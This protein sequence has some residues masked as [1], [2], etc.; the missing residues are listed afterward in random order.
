MGGT[1]AGVL[2][3]GEAQAGSLVAAILAVGSAEGLVLTVEC[4]A[5]P[6]ASQIFVINKEPMDYADDEELLRVL[7]FT[8][9]YPTTETVLDE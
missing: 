8:G 3:H 5:G 6:E 2:G 7:A 1:G 9:A 4:V